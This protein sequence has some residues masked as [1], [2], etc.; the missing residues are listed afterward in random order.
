MRITSLVTSPLIKKQ[1]FS[2]ARPGE[3]RDPVGGE[4][5]KLAGWPAGQRL[6]PEVG[7]AVS[8]EPVLQSFSG[9]RPCQAVRPQR[10][11]AYEMH[12]AA[13]DRNCRD[14]R[15]GDR[16]AFLVAEGQLGPVR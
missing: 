3:V 14:F 16:A 11:L 13:G 12:G 4:V 5:C 2:V 10:H 7:G 9:R 6:F 8:G 1:L 15:Y